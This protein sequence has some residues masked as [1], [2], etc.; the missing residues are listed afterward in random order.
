MK[1]SASILIELCDGNVLRNKLAW[2]TKATAT[3]LT[4][5]NKLFIIIR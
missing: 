1:R 3:R 5:E 2:I 4:Y